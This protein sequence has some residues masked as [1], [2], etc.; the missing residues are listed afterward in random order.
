MP[1]LI[2]VVSILLI[3]LLIPYEPVAFCLMENHKE[4]AIAHLKKI[5]RRKE[6]V[7]APLEELLVD[8]YDY[9]S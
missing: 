5:Y 4:E 3:V 7:S 9:L 2:G 8:H 6:G 1:A